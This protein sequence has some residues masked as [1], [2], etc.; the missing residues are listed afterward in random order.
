[1]ELMTR[2][3]IN[4]KGGFTPSTNNSGIV[5]NFATWMEDTVLSILSP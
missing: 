2:H 1:M 4:R 5:P 3:Y